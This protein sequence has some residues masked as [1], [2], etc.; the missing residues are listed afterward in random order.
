MKIFLPL[1]ALLLLQ[2]VA[3]TGETITPEQAKDYVGQTVT[4][5]GKVAE[6]TEHNGN[7]FINFGA[8]YP[9][10]SF[11]GF[12]ASR[13][14]NYLDGKLTFQALQ[15]QTASITGEVKLY[16][17]KPEIVITKEDQVTEEPHT[18][19]R[20]HFRDEPDKSGRNDPR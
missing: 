15:G 6:V 2:A 5:T 12:V 18:P 13:D 17:G 16:K 7:I 19:R 4:V 1:V 20:G 8:K 10:Q 3:F 11:Y 9:R 14:A